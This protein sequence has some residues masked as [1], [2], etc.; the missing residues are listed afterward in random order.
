MKI[1]LI[2]AMAKNRII[3]HKGQMPWHLRADLQYFKQ[4]TM[5]SPVIMGRKTFEAIGKPLPGRMNIIL[6]ANPAFTRPDCRIFAELDSALQFC[7]GHAEVFVIGGA[8]LYQA[9]LHRA[10][11]LYLTEIDKDFSGDTYFPVIEAQ[12]WREVARR[13]ITNDRSVDFSYSFVK[14]ERACRPAGRR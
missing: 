14:F 8:T 13:S 10:D 9:L 6:S 11:C 12:S 1:S 3:G 7:R 2:V 4:V 5:G